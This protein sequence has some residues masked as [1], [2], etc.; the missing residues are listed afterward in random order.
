MKNRVKYLVFLFLIFSE[1]FS[2]KAV[3]DLKSRDSLLLELDS[4]GLVI[5]E[6]RSEGSDVTAEMKLTTD[7]M[8]RVDRLNS[9]LS[10]MVP[11]PIQTNEKN[12][13]NSSFEI[14]KS[15]ASFLTNHSLID[16]MIIVT[17]SIA[18]ISAILLAL[19][20]LFVS[21]RKN[22]AIKKDEKRKRELVQKK[23]E[24]SRIEKVSQPIQKSIPVVPPKAVAP[25]SNA[26][27]VIEPFSLPPETEDFAGYNSSAQSTS[28]FEQYSENS[29]APTPFVP[30]PALVK[31]PAESEIAPI[32]NR[33]SS[34]GFQSSSVV[35]EQ[36]NVQ[37]VSEKVDN[38]EVVLPVQNRV[39]SAKEEIIS[40]YDNGASSAEIAKRVEMSIDQINLIIHLSG[41]R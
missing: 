29:S 8:G 25:A 40:A 14:S 20:K 10:E 36:Q 13:I 15:I 19:L 41:R 34:E 37:V 33:P 32:E 23:V 27:R 5:R 17:G 24:R 7:L 6:K 28:P 9:E 11:E 22:V 35:Q 38:S 12:E 21:V 1:S 26:N 39:T 4:I 18:L 30:V 2:F 16:I 3:I 31:Q